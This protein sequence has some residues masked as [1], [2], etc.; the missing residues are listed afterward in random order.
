MSIEKCLKKAK[1]RFENGEVESIRIS[2]ITCRTNELM[3]NMSAD[4]RA[5]AMKLANVEADEQNL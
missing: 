4:Y 1:E 3:E 5:N 2:F